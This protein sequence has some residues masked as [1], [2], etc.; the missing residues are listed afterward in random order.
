MIKC[1]HNVATVETYLDYD[2]GSE[3]NLKFVKK[4]KK[5]AYS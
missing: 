1:P 2:S 5:K 3:F 4:K